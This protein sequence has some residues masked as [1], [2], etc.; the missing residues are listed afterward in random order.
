MRISARQ[1]AR[2]GACAEGGGRVGWRR[3]TRWSRGRSGKGREGG[4][5]TRD[6]GLSRGPWLSGGAGGRAGVQRPAH[7]RLAGSGDR[8][9]G[10]GPG[11]GWGCEGQ[12]R[13]GSEGAEELRGDADP[14]GGERGPLSEYPVQ[15]LGRPEVMWGSPRKE[16]CSI[17]EMGGH[18][19]ALEASGV[20]NFGNKKELG[21]SD[22]V[23]GAASQ[24]V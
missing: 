22:E 14:L 17:W 2:G 1:G 24:E 16:G 23:W 8:I 21:G 18:L 12:A 7:A 20:Q 6:R 9:W 13:E 5:G 10:A 19:K 4:S 15:H 3:W 11:W